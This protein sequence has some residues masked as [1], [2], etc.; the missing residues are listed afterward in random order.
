[1]TRFCNSIFGFC[2]LT[3]WD[4]GFGVFEWDMKCLDGIALFPFTNCFKSYC[5]ASAWIIACLA[6]IAG[7]FFPFDPGVLRLKLPGWAGSCL[8]FCGVITSF[9]WWVVLCDPI[10]SGFF[11][12]GLVV[13]ELLLESCCWTEI[14]LVV[15][16]VWWEL[17][18]FNSS[19]T[20]L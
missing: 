13:F 15:S 6:I 11:Y 4:K 20:V 10:R 19:Q 14:V 12:L 16:S 5:A 3:T 1:M 2:K 8:M 18:V 7:G 9:E 17:L